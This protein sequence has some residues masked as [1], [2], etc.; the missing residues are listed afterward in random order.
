LNI[1][2][3]ACAS[4]RDPSRVF[5][6]YYWLI[7]RGL[8]PAVLL[9]TARGF[10]L[11]QDS[12]SVAGELYRSYEGWA[13]GTLYNSQSSVGS[14]GSA[15]PSLRDHQVCRSP[16]NPF[17]CTRG[18]ARG[19]CDAR[20]TADAWSLLRGRLVYLPSFVRS[21]GQPKMPRRRS[22]CVDR[23]GRIIYLRARRSTSTGSDRIMYRMHQRS[24][25]SACA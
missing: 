9:T 25:E 21:S 16:R 22:K 23:R 18:A 13:D 2:A 5:D 6:R 24:L 17:S 19:R 8:R 11:V 1:C 4:D 20:G 7:Q 12:M 14:T 3:V 10:L 15:K